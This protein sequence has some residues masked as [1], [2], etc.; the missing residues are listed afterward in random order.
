VT[1]PVAPSRVNPVMT[2]KTNL[3]WPAWST[4]ALAGMIITSLATVAAVLR[5]IF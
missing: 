3:L 1:E 4:W 5:D 2:T